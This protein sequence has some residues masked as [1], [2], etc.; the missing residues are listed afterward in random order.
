MGDALTG[1]AGRSAAGHG[2]QARGAVKRAVLGLRLLGRAG[3]AQEGKRGRRA[4][5][6]KRKKMEP[7]RKQGKE[8]RRKMILFFFFYNFPNPFLIQISILFEIFNKFQTF[9]KCYAAACMHQKVSNL[10]FN[11]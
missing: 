5:R 3:P 1:G 2:E 7:G 9:T 8:G 4:G 11:F 6:G 10:I